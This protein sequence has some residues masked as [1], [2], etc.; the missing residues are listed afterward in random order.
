M[1]LLNGLKK[2]SVDFNKI[3]LSIKEHW[4][5]IAV[6]I[7]LSTSVIA[8][9]CLYVMDVEYSASTKIYI[10]N[11]KPD[12][13]EAQYNDIL[14]AEKLA[15]VCK[16]IAKSDKVINAAKK[17]LGSDT[18]INRSK[19]TVNSPVTSMIQLVVKDKSPQRAADIANAITDVLIV[20]AK[21]ITKISNITPIDKATIPTTPDTSNIKIYC[22]LAAIV[23]MVIGIG[24]VIMIEMFDKTIKGPDDITEQYGL[25]IL[26]L[27]PK[28][29][30]NETEGSKG[31][32]KSYGRQKA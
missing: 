32:G 14:T 16:E 27:I 15:G 11:D 30:K 19:I 31:R 8:Y 17:E 24:I 26:G 25:T 22:I 13:E 21:E 7:I 5:I 6:S 4:Y 29:V 28:V 23:G 9:Y 2:G 12:D 10:S 18:Y 20:N 3:L 1:N